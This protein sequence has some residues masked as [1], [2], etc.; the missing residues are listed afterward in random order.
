MRTY[1]QKIYI[2]A[3]LTSSHSLGFVYSQIGWRCENTTSRWFN[4]T[5]LI[6][7]LKVTVTTFQSESPFSPKKGHFLAELP[8]FFGDTKR[9]PNWITWHPFPVF[10]WKK[11]MWKHK[12]LEKTSQN[13][14]PSNFHYDMGELVLQL[15]VRATFIRLFSQ[16]KPIT[17][18][19]P[20]IWTEEFSQETL[21]Q[22]SRE[23]PRLQDW[24]LDPNRSDGVMSHAEEHGWWC[25]PNR[26]NA[27]TYNKRRFFLGE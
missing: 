12:K 6:S 2:M 21:A 13:D 22:I 7:Q 24:G 9:S 5:F 8:G 26:K 1:Q 20:K 17:K 23:D 14:P 25:V 10:R 11:R 19:L 27:R 3:A 16:T 15:H 18:K 4:V